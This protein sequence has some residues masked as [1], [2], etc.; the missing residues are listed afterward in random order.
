MTIKGISS[1]TIHAPSS[2]FVTATMTSTTPVTRAPKPLMKALVLHP[3][4]FT[5]RQWIT[6]PACDSVKEMN[7]P[8]MYNGSSDCVSPRKPT[9]S[10]AA[11]SDRTRMPLE[12]AR[13]SPWFMNWRGRYRSRETIDARRGKSAY[14]VFAASTRI[15][16]VAA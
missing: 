3:G 16:V 5:C 9:M 1:S 15:S 7:T 2:V 14:A 10:T 4:V 11:N 6:M 13:R 12:N 8:I